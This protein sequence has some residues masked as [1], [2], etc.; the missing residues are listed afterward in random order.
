MALAH[1]QS[2][3]GLT[4]ESV[5]WVTL[6]LCSGG[7]CA[8]TS[9]EPSTAA[10]PRGHRERGTRRQ[11]LPIS[12][13]DVPE[14]VGSHCGGKRT[15]CTHLG[16]GKS[17]SG[18][19]VLV[20]DS[21]TSGATPSL[22]FGA[23]P[24]LTFGPYCPFSVLPQSLSTSSSFCPFLAWL[25]LLT[26]QVLRE[27]ALTSPSGSGPPSLRSDSPCPLSAAP[28][29][30]THVTMNHVSAQPSPHQPGVLQ[31]HPDTAHQSYLR[32]HR[33]RA[34]SSSSDASPKS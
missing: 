22:T 1:P 16:V 13:K 17:P 6:P 7:L 10:I 26:P 3:Q 15:Q 24:S 4:A 12:H 34:D 33:S 9:S 5:L 20:G 11:C 25:A 19:V 8:R 18:P 29:L 32:P 23:T 2:L 28:A 30:F 27:A 14:A 31:F 21:L